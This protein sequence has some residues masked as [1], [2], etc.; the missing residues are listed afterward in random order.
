VLMD[1]AYFGG[2]E[3]H[4]NEVR[5]AVNLPLLYKEFVVDLWQVWHARS[6]EA[7]A[8]LLIA[9]VLSDAEIKELMIESKEAGLAVLLEVH[10]EEELDR[11]IRLEAPVIGMNNRDLK[12]FRTTVETT[13]DLA[14]K[15]PEETILIS[16]SGIRSAEDLKRLADVGVKGVLVGEHLLRQPN[17]KEA[18][19]SLRGE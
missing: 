4:F 19:E 14:G 7:S 2:G 10:D 5:A 1:Q 8:I 13:L 11:A 6:L 12:T 15:V 3:D 17:L 18:V 9:S 16:E